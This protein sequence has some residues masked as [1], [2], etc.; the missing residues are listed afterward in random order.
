M[1]VSLWELAAML[2][3]AFGP[4]LSGWILQNFDWQWLFLMN[5]PI[6][7]I[8][9]LFV[10]MYIPYYRLNVPKSFDGLGFLTVVLSSSSLLLSL[11]QGHN[12]G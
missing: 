6:V 1:A 12:W 9:I 4:T 10:Y 7:I 11:G 5:I 3:P 8:A 2:A